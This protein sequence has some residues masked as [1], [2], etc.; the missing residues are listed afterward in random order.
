M[1]AKV[2]QEFNSQ[3]NRV[4]ILNFIKHIHPAKIPLKALSFCNTWGL[5]GMALVLF[6][7]LV[8]TGT[9]MLFVYKPF[10]GLAY[11]SILSI[12][13]EYIFGQLIRNIH[14][15][16]AS[17]LVIIVFSHILRVFLTG[18]Y[19]GNR[20]FNW[21]IGLSIFL[22]V[23]LSCFTGYLL[24][25]DQIAFWAVTI[26]INILDYLP[27]G[28]WLKEIITQGGEVSAKT[29]QLF[30]TMHTTVLPGS[31]FLILS[32]HFWKIRKAKGVVTSGLNQIS[33]SEK[34]VMV[35]TIPHLLLREATVA[36]VLIALVM[37][38][39]S[40]FNAP[41]QDMANAGLSP[42]PAKAPWYFSGLQELLLHFHPFFA[43]FLIP[44]VVLSLLFCLPYINSDNSQSG[45]WFIS[46]KGK[47]T[48]LMSIFTAFIITPAFILA[49]EYLIDLE[50]FIPGI[51]SWISLGLVPV[52]FIFCLLIIYYY[53]M[54][55]RFDLTR[56]ESVQMFFLLMVTIFI[57]LT[58]TGIWFRG[59]NMTLMWAG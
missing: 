4:S 31:L 2:N 16:S 1:S 20:K 23:L 24:P 10:P 5:G 41:L 15:F 19:N 8:G 25:W 3:K 33:D 38:V 55:K 14:Y 51:S 26:C 45:M 13:T 50:S 49:D 35:D 12:Q 58:I 59:E 40:T 22:I 6:V 47:Q 28:E 11:E 48:S 37:T 9:L 18:G 42:N 44:F 46:K 17:F 27:A 29:L 57:V 32:I 56:G 39:S 21:M 43:A 52:I 30:F 54:I 36:L 34:P 53:L 7:L